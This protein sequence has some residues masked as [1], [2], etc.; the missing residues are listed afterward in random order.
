MSSGYQP[1]NVVN[2]QV[3]STS[4]VWVPL[5]YLPPQA[6]APFY[7]GDVAN[8]YVFTGEAWVPCLAKGSAPV[9]S[10]GAMATPKRQGGLGRKGRV[11]IGVIAVLAV[12][13]VI[14]KLMDRPAGPDVEAKFLEEVQAAQEAT[15]DNGAQVIEAK[16]A[17]GHRLCD[18]LPSGLKIE[19]WQGTVVTVTDELGGDD[20]I[21]KIELAKGITVDADTGFFDTGI[22]AGSALYAEVAALAKGQT[23]TFSGR[24][25]KDKT[26]CIKETSIMDENGLRTPRFAFEFSSVQ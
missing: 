19:G 6:E 16:V 5:R 25:Q 26:Y 21:L 4:G 23:V 14:G 9:G 3:L 24:F 12:L 18:I 13:A 20:A 15:A 2:G 7:V 1:G 10:I 11:V 8:G 22:K 17:R